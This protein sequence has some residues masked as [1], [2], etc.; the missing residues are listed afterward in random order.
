[1]CDKLIEGCVSVLQALS[2]AGSLSVMR[3]ILRPLGVSSKHPGNNQKCLQT[4]PSVPRGDGIATPPPQLRNA[5]LGDL[6]NDLQRAT[7][8]RF[9][10]DVIQSPGDTH[11]W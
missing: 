2:S 3:A 6:I 4:L 5:H 7:T 11:Q 9:K 1:M 8:L 10:G